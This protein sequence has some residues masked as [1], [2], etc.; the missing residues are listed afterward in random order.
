MVLIEDSDTDSY[1][2]IGDVMAS[3]Y[4]PKRVESGGWTG[5]HQ[6]WVILKS[7]TKPEIVLPFQV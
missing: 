7:I 4:T 6:I 5:A 3:D 2:A 1:V